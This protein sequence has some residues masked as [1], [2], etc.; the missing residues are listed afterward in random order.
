MLKRAL[1]VMGAAIM[2]AGC[3]SEHDLGRKDSPTAASMDNMFFA[4]IAITN[5]AEIQ[6]SQSALSQSQNPG[7]KQY[8]Q[9]MIEDHTQAQAQLASL[10]QSKGAMLPTKVDAMHMDMVSNLQKLQGMQFDHQYI[11][12]QIAA[13]KAAIVETQHEAYTGNDPDV[14]TMAMQMIPTLKMH[15]QMAQALQTNMSNSMSGMNGM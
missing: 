3:Q 11:Q 15:L 6:E 7:I 2:V 13:H 4:D 9:K 12:D 10:A 5:M 14:K 8:A 1:V